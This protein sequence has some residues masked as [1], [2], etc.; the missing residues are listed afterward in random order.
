MDNLH[1]FFAGELYFL[2]CSLLLNM[3]IAKTD[4]KYMKW[5]VSIFFIKPL[6]L[7]FCNSSSV[8]LVLLSI[9][10]WKY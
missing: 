8:L 6:F 3:I 4:V 7:F 2:I 10:P 1:T 5:N 9:Y